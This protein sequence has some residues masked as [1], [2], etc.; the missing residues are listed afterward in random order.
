MAKDLALN[1]YLWRLSQGG[2]WNYEFYKQKKEENE[3]IISDLIERKEKYKD[4]E[5]ICELITTRIGMLEEHMADFDTIIY[6]GEMYD[7]VYNSENSSEIRHTIYNMESVS[8]VY[9]YLEGL[10]NET[11]KKICD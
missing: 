9:E 5:V 7:I 8:E 6:F 3:K 11:S 10:K 2:T 1:N 4:D